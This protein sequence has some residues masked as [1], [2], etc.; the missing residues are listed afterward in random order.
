MPFELSPFAWAIMTAIAFFIIV[1][2]MFWDSFKDLFGDF[3]DLLFPALV[4]EAL[5]GWLG[6]REGGS[7]KMILLLLGCLASGMVVFFRLSAP[8]RETIG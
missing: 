7:L 1:G 6:P 5:V 3:F 8:A 2:R 4:Y